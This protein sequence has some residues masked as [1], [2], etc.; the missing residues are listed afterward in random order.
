M[1]INITDEL[2][3]ATTKGKI[4]SAKEVYLT[5]DTENLQQIGEKTHQLEDSIK[6][7]AATGGAS[8]AV[9]V[10]FDNAA[11]G[12][13]AVNTQ[14]AIDELSSK[15]KSQDIEL[16]KKANTKDL[17]GTESNYVEGYGL[18]PQG[19][20]WAGQ[21]N[22]SYLTFIPYDEGDIDWYHCGVA[23]KDYLS[24][25]T[26]C[27]YDENKSFLDKFGYGSDNKR[28]ICESSI[29]ERTKYI[30]ACF[31]TSKKSSAFVKI[32]NKIY[33]PTDYYEGINQK[34]GDTS[35]LTEGYSNIVD[36]VNALNRKGIQKYDGTLSDKWK[37]N[38][39]SAYENMLSDYKIRPNT[40][41]PMFVSTDQHGRGLWQHIF[42][43]NLDTNSSMEMLSINLGDTVV[44]YFNYLELEKYYKQI[45]DAHNYISISGNHDS[46]SSNNVEENAS[47][48]DITK[49]FNTTDIQ[50]IKGETNNDDYIVY[51][52][53]HKV[54][55]VCVDGYSKVQSS[56]E[57]TEKL[58]YMEPSEYDWL[59]SELSK[60]DSYDIIVL[61]HWYLQEGKDIDPYKDRN[62]NDTKELSYDQYGG[63]RFFA[64]LADLYRARKINAKGSIQDRNGNSHTYDFS[65]CK[66]NLLCLLH[67]HQHQEMY[68]YKGK[69][70]SYVFDG[71]CSNYWAAFALIDRE[72][73][74]LKIYAFDNEKVLDK[75]NLSLKKQEE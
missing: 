55:F 27:L 8:T 25:V 73:E 57:T 62:G 41:I 74:H 56:E 75:L 34:I 49:F 61:Q 14:A 44:D 47:A 54:K 53:E 13:T 45:K 38:C 32:G 65:N 64:D 60:D 18:T 43:G 48:F 36:A 10:T 69:L 23:N 26:L 6:N 7:I 2:H 17:Y 4:A 70:L 51:D 29:N 66:T 33:T 31:I 50:R 11:S 71:F 52:N 67:G 72:D 9:A 22:A 15:N 20:A 40:S 21:G 30:Q 5:G 3:A 28:F 19:A 42:A 12:M 63:K 24:Y 35:K 1:P 39:K 37:Q 46:Y 59:I 58:K 16:S 68:A